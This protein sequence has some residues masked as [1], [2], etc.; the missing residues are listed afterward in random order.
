METSYQATL[1]ER[2]KEVATLELKLEKERQRVEGYKQAMASNRLQLIEE[3]KKLK[4]VNPHLGP[5]LALAFAVMC[6]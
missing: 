3:R 1:T 5:L 2:C 4:L 6:I